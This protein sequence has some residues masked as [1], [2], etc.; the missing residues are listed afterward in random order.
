M[1][2]GRGGGNGVLEAELCHGE[3]VGWQGSAGALAIADGANVALVVFVYRIGM[4]RRHGGCCLRCRRLVRP[5]LK[6]E[7][8]LA[9][10]TRFEHCLM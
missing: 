10:K 8:R 2:R 3:R 4:N 5:P 7:K 9:K 6:K 1:A